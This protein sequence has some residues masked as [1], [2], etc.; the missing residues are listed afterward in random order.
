MLA[1]DRYERHAAEAK[2]GRHTDGQNLQPKHND[3][4]VYEREADRPCSG[5]VKNDAVQLTLQ[6][7]ERRC[8]HSL[9]A[10]RRSLQRVITTDT[11][12]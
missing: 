3:A 2:K 6:Q 10:L 5:V 1:L 7:Q 12:Y 8:H 9:H 11:Y 4:D